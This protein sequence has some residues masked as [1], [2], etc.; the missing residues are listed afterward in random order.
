MS[1]LP[2]RLTESHASVA[3]T[4]KRFVGA[5]YLAW[6]GATWLLEKRVGL[7]ARY[8]PAG[9]TLYALLANVAIGTL[10]ASA[11]A[12][13]SVLPEKDGEREGARPAAWRARPQLLILTAI[14][15]GI[16]VVAAA[17]P[18]ARV[19]VVLLNAFAQILP[20]SI[21]EIV[22]CWL[23][24]GVAAHRA[25]SR[26]GEVAATILAIIVADL[27]FALYHVAHSAPFDRP[28]MIAF[29]ALPGLVT[30]IV[31]FVARD[32]VSAI[33]VQNFFAMIGITKN[34][35]LDVFRHPFVWAYATAAL[36]AASAVFALR[37]SG[38]WPS[39]T[40]ARRGAAS[41]ASRAGRTREVA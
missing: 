19:P 30:G 41:V 26:Y 21:A 7:F 24:L 29:L 4:R 31:V 8:D 36:A 35:D 33:L 20:T 34:A 38:S 2:Q 9:R 1:V 3:R 22:T 27:S 11:V 25:A 6:I 23:L 28:D 37:G 32:R 5:I 39:R 15:G 10:L 14:V 13:R 12:R 16:V 18:A 17:P 40:S